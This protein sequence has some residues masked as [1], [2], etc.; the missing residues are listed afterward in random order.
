MSA[1]DVRRSIGLDA[2][3]S[4]EAL[5]KVQSSRNEPEMPLS[6]SQEAVVASEYTKLDSLHTRIAT[7]RLYSEHPDSPDGALFDLLRLP[8]ARS[9]LDIG[10][11]T[12]EFL[13]TLA[14]TGHSGRLVGIDTSAEAVEAI[15]HVGEVQAI[16]ASAIALPFSD[17]NF[18]VAT[19]R[20]MLYHVPDPGP[21]LEEARRVLRSGGTFAAVVNHSETVPR[22]ITLVRDVVRE[23][24]VIAAP[25]PLNGVHSGSL[26]S[27][28]Q[29]VFG[30]HEVRR[31]DNALIFDRPE[32]LA[33]FAGALLSFCG[34]PPEA[35]GHASLVQELADRAEGW[36]R[37]SHTPWRDPKGY[38]V[39]TA[40]VP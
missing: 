17:G 4:L 19:A 23:A 7:H 16:E 1:A 12:G 28:V 32:P 30:N 5:H 8:S 35:V 20:H 6:R 18:D 36:F 21:A 2:P 13:Q 15:G 27:L 26:P 10:C 24:G 29:Q 38:I 37:D 31:F 22:T 40:L 34:V 9:L 14:N 25:S 11:G 33:V 39:C 3:L